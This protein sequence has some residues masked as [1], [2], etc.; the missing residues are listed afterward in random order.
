MI[1][2]PKLIERPIIESEN[3]AVIACLTENIKDHL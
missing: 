2:H 1:L 3:A